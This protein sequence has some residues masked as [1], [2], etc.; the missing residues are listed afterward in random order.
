MLNRGDFL[1]LVLS[2]GMFLLTIFL[3][4][5]VERLEDYVAKFRGIE[6]APDLAALHKRNQSR[7]LGNDNRNGVGILRHTNRSAVTRPEISRQ[8]WI[9]RQRQK[10]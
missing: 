3:R 5:G 7:F 1:S 4:R 8:T 9:Q 2:L 10:A 6:P